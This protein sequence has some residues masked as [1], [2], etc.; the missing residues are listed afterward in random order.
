MKSVN[1]IKTLISRL[2]FLPKSAFG[3]DISDASIEALEL[4]KNLGQIKVSAY[5]RVRLPS[6]VV[7]DGEILQRE[8]LVEAIRQVLLS[9]K[10][11]PIKNKNVILSLPEIKVF[12]HI[13]QMPAAVSDEQMSE[14]IQYA[15]EEIIPFF[16][17][18]IYHDYRVI[19]KHEDKQEVFYFACPKN[20][21]DSY[22]EA[23]NQAGLQP[24][25]F[26]AESFAIARALTSK[27]PLAGVVIAD[28][29][30]RTTMISIFDNHGIRYSNNI[31]TAGRAF[32]DRIAASEN[33]SHDQAERIKREKGLIGKE[34]QIKIILEPMLSQIIQEINQAVEIY[35]KKSS[36][37]INKIVL[38]GGS[39]LMPGL[40]EHFAYLTSLEVE[41]G[42]PLA[43][44]KHDKQFFSTQPAI[45]FSTV[46]G[47]A[48]RGLSQE[49]IMPDTGKIDKKEEK[50]AIEKS[51]KSILLKKK[52]SLKINI[53]NKRLTVMVG[54]F[55]LL[56]AIF[57]VLYFLQ[58]D[59][60]DSLI[61]FKSYDYPAGP[62]EY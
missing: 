24:V 13:F 59:K 11:H 7:S 57:V 51:D 5:G 3:L 54:V 25:V 44:I 41:L 21:I 19:K 1:L 6:G 23:L 50:K 14:S 15:A 17:D 61:Q 26:E 18:Q 8:K 55:I 52:F 47:L 9:A 28:I 16:S 22:S 46:F 42:D 56:I 4:K 31:S 37:T 58:K 49:M 60:E 43:G 30:A 48:Q 53:K 35:Q 36:S 38:V 32:T 12:S 62:V 2:S 29:G 20:V 40:K 39:S 45:L 34:S 27:D 33:I 10:P